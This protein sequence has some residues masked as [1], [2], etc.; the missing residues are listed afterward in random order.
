M[1]SEHESDAQK[2]HPQDRY[3]RRIRRRERS[4]RLYP[5]SQVRRPR[6]HWALEKSSTVPAR[7]FE[8]KH[9]DGCTG[10]TDGQASKRGTPV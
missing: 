2:A 7:R 8:L 6:R 10:D 1:L 4:P 3:P 9:N 5:K